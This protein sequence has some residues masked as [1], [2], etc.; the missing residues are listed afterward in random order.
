MITLFIFHFEITGK[1][2]K[3]LHL[4]KIKAIFIIFEVFYFEISGKDNKEKQS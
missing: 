2:N 1:H 4:K 3:D